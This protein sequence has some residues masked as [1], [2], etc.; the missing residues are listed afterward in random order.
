MSDR[1]EL[2][3]LFT[4]YWKYLAINAA[5]EL[6]VFDLI[7]ETNHTLDDLLSNSTLDIRLMK[8]L[9][10]FLIDEEYIMC[11]SSEE[12]L[13]TEKGHLLRESNKNGLYYAC[14][15]WSE[16][17]LS[18]WQN[19]VHTL[20]TGQSAF[21]HLYQKPYFDYLNENPEKLINYHKAM[22]AYA[23]EDY[24]ELPN[25]IDFS[26]HTCVMDVGG[27]YGAAIKRIKES[28]PLL[29]CVLFDLE[30]VVGSDIYENVECIGGDFFEGIPACADA[31][32]LSRV[33]HDWNDEKALRILSNCFNA[34]PN[35]GKLYIVENCKDLISNK[36]SLLSLNMAVMCDSFE[37]TSHAYIAL[38]ASQGFR[39]LELRTLN[40]LQTILIFSK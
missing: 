28:N 36:L 17:H 25:R 10:E 15:N 18:A 7:Y 13:L 6:K 4:S 23:K 29:R 40:A 3:Q 22:L 8:I 14:L 20:K 16:E 2:K 12:L 39:F 38:C 31:I 33:I 26:I 34:L 5:C 9:I 30:K 37:R 24:E 19:L 11:N 21:E 27:G 35:G 1:S 32:I